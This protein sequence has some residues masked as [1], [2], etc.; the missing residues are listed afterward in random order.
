ML[1]TK[2]KSV[3]IPY[4]AGPKFLARINKIARLNRKFAVYPVKTYEIS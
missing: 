3:Y 1:P 4:L 2:R